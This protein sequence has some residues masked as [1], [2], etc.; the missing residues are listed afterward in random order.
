MAP[1]FLTWGQSGLYTRVGMTSHKTVT[2]A[3]GLL[4]VPR[5]P[6]EVVRK[7][8]L[9]AE[10]IDAGT[11]KLGDRITAPY[12]C[13]VSRAAWNAYVEEGWAVCKIVDLAESHYR[14]ALQQ[15]PKHPMALN[16]LAWL[17]AKE[18]KDYATALEL[19]NKLGVPTDA[20]GFLGVKGARALPELH[21]EGIYVVG[22]CESPKDIAGCIAQAEAVSAVVVSEV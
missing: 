16:D 8:E 14:K 12:D 3:A 15:N 5:R 6:L 13:I 7:G 18:R 2:K 21:K 20:Q 11:Y 10:V 19:A 4:S 9:L 22:A 17:L 1:F